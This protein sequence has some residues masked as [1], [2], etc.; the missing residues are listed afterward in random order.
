LVIRSEVDTLRPAGRIS[1]AYLH[2]RVIRFEN[3]VAGTVDLSA[4]MAEM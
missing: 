4:D 3:S 1:S 2:L